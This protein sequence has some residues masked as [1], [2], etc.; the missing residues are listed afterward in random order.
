MGA[1]RPGRPDRCRN[2]LTPMLDAFLFL[3]TFGLLAMGLRR[4]FVWVLAYIYID[5]LAPQKIGWTLTPMVP[6]SLIAFVAAFAG[7]LL[8]DNKEGARFTFRQ[9]LIA[10]LLAYVT[11]TATWAAYPEFGWQKR[12]WVWKA[13]VFA[14]FLP[15]TLRT[16]LR[17][18]ATVLTMVL[19]I[20]AIII[21]GGLKT[22]AGGGGYGTLYFFVSDNSGLYASST[23]ACVAIAVIPLIL[24]LTKYGTI[25]PPDWRV[26]LFA[27]ALIFACLLIPVGT[28]ARTGL[29]CAALMAALLRRSAKHRFVYAMLAPLAVAIAVPFLPQSYM[30]RMSTIQNHQE[31]ESAET[32]VAVWQWTWNYVKD[33]PLGGG[34]EAYRANSFSYKKQVETG[35]ANASST[36]TILVTDKGRAYHSAYFEMLG[37]QGWPGIALWI[38]L[39]AL[40]LWHMEWIRRRLKKRDDP[41]DRPL[42]DLATAL[43]N[44]QIVYLVGALFVGIAFQPFVFMLIALQ[45]ALWTMVRRAEQARAAS[46]GKK[47]TAAKAG[48]R[49]S[50]PVPQSSPA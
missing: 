43:Q 30:D 2:R 42:R 9:G 34:F 36:E 5:I 21:S 49:A 14:I 50:K 8:A 19:S 44:G 23:I 17:I 29:L 40:G 6:F 4:P 15:L 20:A 26:K 1:S 41:A 31:D 7:W 47:R 24:W 22:V 27:A 38:W 18:E 45:I 3:F 33:H 35:D 12:D 16:R 11:L 39:Q 28:E 32:R 37:E 25:F 46:E 10:A 13:L 48:P